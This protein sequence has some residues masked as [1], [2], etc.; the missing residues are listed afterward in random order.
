MLLQVQA[1]NQIGTSV[2]GLRNQQLKSTSPR[3]TCARNGV[4]PAF[5]W[6]WVHVH[7]P[8]ARGD[9][10]NVSNDFHV[11]VGI[12]MVCSGQQLIAKPWFAA[13]KPQFLSGNVRNGMTIYWQAAFRTPETSW[14]DQ[15]SFPFLRR[16]WGPS[17]ILIGSWFVDCVQQ[18]PDTYGEGE[19]TRYDVRLSQ[20]V[21][22]PNT[23]A[24][25]LILF[26]GVVVMT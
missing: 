1:C 26:G 10:Q 2:A 7:L 24:T 20:H 8:N 3:L 16:F 12:G 5:R 19:V 21:R 14:K 13:R 17:W 18:V 6:R 22:K 15:V 11:V 23:C 9:S 25:V 4:L